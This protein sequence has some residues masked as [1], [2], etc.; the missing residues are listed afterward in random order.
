MMGMSKYTF[1]VNKYCIE[2]DERFF[3]YV[4]VIDANRIVELL[5]E[6]DAQIQ[7]LHQAIDDLSDYI[8]ELRGGVRW[9]ELS[10][11]LSM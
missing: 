9:I 4:D 3:A 8:E 1:N 10:N 11:S 7:E 5:N 2:K 6:Q